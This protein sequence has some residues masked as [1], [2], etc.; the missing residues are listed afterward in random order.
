MSGWVGWLVLSCSRS[1]CGRRRARTSLVSRR[2]RWAGPSRRGSRT[3]RGPPVAE[4]A[5]VR[6]V[7]A[8]LDSACGLWRAQLSVPHPPRGPEAR[9]F[10]KTAGLEHTSRKASR[11]ARLAGSY[12]LN[13]RVTSTQLLK[14]TVTAPPPISHRRKHGDFC[15]FGHCSTPAFSLVP[16]AE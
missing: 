13:S 2:A 10:L 12:R 3:P 16:G 6:S 5:P 7:A 1:L 15:L 8:P 4:A 14:N 9:G 11:S